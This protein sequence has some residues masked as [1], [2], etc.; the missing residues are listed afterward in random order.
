MGSRRRARPP[1]ARR[2]RAVCDARCWC[3]VPPVRARAPSPMIFCPS[4]SAR[5]MTGLPD[6]A[7]PAAAAATPARGRIP[8]GGRWSRSLARGTRAGESIVAVARRWLLASA[9]SPILADQ[10]VILIEG[11][12]RANEQTQNALLKALEEPSPR[13][14]FVLIADEPGRLLP[15]IRSRA[16]PL[17]VGPVE[18]GCGTGWSSTSAQT[19]TDR[20]ELLPAW[21]AGSPGARSDM[22]GSPTCSHGARQRSASCWT[23]RQRVGGAVRLGPPP[24]GHRRQGGRQRWRR[25]NR[26]MTR[27]RARPAQRSRA[28]PA[29][30]RCSAGRCSRPDDGGCRSTAAGVDRDGSRADRERRGGRRPPGL[31]AFTALAGRIA[32]GLRQNAAA[33]PGGRHAGL[34]ADGSAATPRADGERQ[35]LTAHVAGRV[36]ELASGGGSDPAPPS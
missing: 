3:T 25:W 35:R 34:A 29:G 14:M 11:A 20:A 9:G 4:S 7:T 33:R 1:Y 27:H 6:P 18:A 15:T 32:D 26:L 12:D 10:R 23:H 16:Q 22:R 36:Q 13:Q 28:P 31:I 30:H 5:R 21:P 19:P 17:R 8:T 2:S 24:A